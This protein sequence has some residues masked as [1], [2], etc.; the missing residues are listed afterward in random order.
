MITTRRQFIKQNMLAAGAL[1][2]PATLQEKNIVMTVRGP[3]PARSM[4]LTLVHEH[5]LVDFIGA[6]SIVPGRYNRKEAFDLALPHLRDLYNKGCRTLVECTPQW[7]GRD[8]LLLRELSAASKLHILTNTGYYGAAEEKFLPASLK[9]T[10][11]AQL[12]AAW[13]DEYTKGIGETGIKPGFMKL[14][15]DD[16]PFTDNI[17]KILKAGALTHRSTGLPIAIHTSKGGNPAREE[18]RLLT[19]NGAAPDAFIWVHAQNEQDPAVYEEI[20]RAGAWVELDGFHRDQTD[21]YVAMLLRLKI[22]RCW[23]RVLVS[24]DAGWYHVGEPGGGNFRPYLDI[25]DHLLP[26]MRKSGFTEED[27]NQL[28]VI[29][30]SLAFCIR[31]I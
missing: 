14:G 10:T 7:L 3:I 19:E 18:L 23:H 16:L 8:P 17:Q 2:F 5:I 20:A 31:K 6:D 26:A 28:M 25:F 22:Q 15:A 9:T 1:L 27:I 11:A 12:A 24:Q 13:A 30:P 29:N 21:A 4:G